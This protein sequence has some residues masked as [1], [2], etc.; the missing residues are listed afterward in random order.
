MANKRKHEYIEAIDTMANLIKE[1]KR[2]K[3]IVDYVKEYMTD[4]YTFTCPFLLLGLSRS[5]KSTFL[6]KYIYECIKKNFCAKQSTILLI[7]TRAPGTVKIF[8]DLELLVSKRIISTVKLLHV[9]FFE[10]LE[11]FKTKHESLIKIKASNRDVWRGK[12]YT[13]VDDAPEC[14]SGSS[15]N[16]TVKSTANFWSSLMS[17][18]SHMDTQVIFSVQSLSMI[19]SSLIKDQIKIVI[20]FHLPS[21]EKF[22][23]YKKTISS[24]AT[25]NV[26]YDELKKNLSE[27]V[28]V[29]VRQTEVKRKYSLY[30]A[31]CNDNNALL[32]LS[33]EV[34][35]KFIENITA[36]G[37]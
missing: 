32:K 29:E 12:I 3:V 9:H 22:K 35:S 17:R 33:Y 21:V 36:C 5:G 37:N 27:I 7:L 19:S 13:I 18:G 28:T 24:L 6:A 26:T 10:E 1:P 23:H 31:G 2:Q 16:Q 11:P 4:K 15:E 30:I 25:C 20:F 8:K 34:P 14:I